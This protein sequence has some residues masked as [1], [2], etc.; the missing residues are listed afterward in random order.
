ML[1]SL[2]GYRIA[3]FTR[4]LP[5]PLG[6][7]FLAEMGAEVVKLED[8]KNPDPVR[9]Y[10]PFRDGISW[11]FVLLNAG[12]AHVEYDRELP[13]HRFAL[14]QFLAQCDVL[15]EQFRPGTMEKMGLGYER[16][17]TINPRIVYVSVSGYADSAEAFQSAG[18]DINYMAESGCLAFLRDGEQRP[19]IPA[20]QMADVA[21]GSFGLV[22][23]VLSGLL[24]RERTGKGTY[25]RVSMTSMA[26]HIAF[27]PLV[28]QQLHGNLDGF[29]LGGNL[30]NYT[31]YA[32]RNGYVAVG[33]LEPKFWMA[34]CQAMERSEWYNRLFSDGDG[35]QALRQ[36]VAATLKT[37]TTD[38]VLRKCAHPDCC[39][40]L[41]REGTAVFKS[42]ASHPSEYFVWQEGT[43]TLQV[44]T[45]V[46]SLPANWDAPSPGAHNKRYGF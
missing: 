4:L 13:E 34:F 9:Q 24:N 6:C 37:M 28:W 42:P 32:C 5:G 26:R 40:S 44:P 14:E 29:L 7:R 23:A 22:M 17:I 39:V 21:G 11:L 45:F 19:V 43:L 1:R 27:L 20:F 15:V 12:K 31:I 36:E 2:D 38:E 46:S 18:H 35:G 8:V 10:P 25:I 3:D 41:V 30:P 33:A 16:V